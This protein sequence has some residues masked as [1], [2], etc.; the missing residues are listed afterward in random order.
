MNNELYE[1][2]TQ[3]QWL[4]HR[5]QIRGWAE[6]GPLA[7]TTR[8]QGRI[9]ALLKMKDGIST[10]DLSYLLGVRVS[11]L[12]ELLAKLEKTGYVSR[13]PAEQDKRVML[14]KL[15]K[16]GA[17]EQQPAPFDFGDI[18]S[19]LSEEEQERFGDYLDRIIAALHANFGDEEE[20]A[21]EKIEALRER[22][23][24]MAGFFDRHGQDFRNGRAFPRGPQTGFGPDRCW[25]H[26]FPGP[27]GFH[28]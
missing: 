5:Q 6:N 17:S 10:K 18:F 11:S 4:L 7:D 13:E 24:E 20:D 28:Q 19:C 27:R 22:F 3:L 23:G 12:N 1:K 21:R 8:G 14:V 15:T 25:P 16:K 9:L 2:L 26:G